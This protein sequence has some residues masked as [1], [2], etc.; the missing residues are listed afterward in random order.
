VRFYAGE[1][2]RGDEVDLMS[3]CLLIGAAQGGEGVSLARL[4]VLG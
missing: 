3:I 4:W 1:A 2:E